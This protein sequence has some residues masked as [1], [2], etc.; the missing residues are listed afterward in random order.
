MAVTKIDIS[1]LEDVGGANNLVKLDSNAK[2]PAGTGANLLNKP[3]PLTSASDP[4]TDSNKALGTEWLNKTSGEM[5]ICTDATVGQNIWTNVGGGSGDVA[6]FHGSGSSY[7]FSATGG[8]GPVDYTIDKFSFTASSNAIDVGDVTDDRRSCGGAFSTTHGYVHGGAALGLTNIIDKYSL[9]AT[10]NATD[11]GDLTGARTTMNGA[12]SLAYGYSFGGEP[13]TNVI[14]KY[15]FAS[16]TNATDHGDLTTSDRRDRGG[17]TQSTTHGYAMGGT[18]TDIIDKWTFDAN[19]NATDVGNLT[20]EGYSMGSNSNGTYGYV[21]GRISASNHNII[22]KFSMV[23]DGNA[24]D[25]GDM[26]VAQHGC[27]G[28]NSL[29]HGYIAG[30]YAPASANIEKFSFASDG[31]SVD[32]NQDLTVARGSGGS[33]QV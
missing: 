19:S 13:A 15:P 3:G 23:S 16:D 27:F 10:G 26:T 32:A 22:D 5:Y 29:T 2:I 11:V 14:D 12:S 33:A 20:Q 8:T 30:A 24:T 4:A 28:Q 17:G 25:V 1:L 9:T 6:P 18:R 7:G 21:T 31:N